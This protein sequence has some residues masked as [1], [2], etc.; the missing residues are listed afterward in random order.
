PDTS[1]SC[2]NCGQKLAGGGVRQATATFSRRKLSQSVVEG[3]PFKPQELIA[4]RYLIK[5]TVAA[6]PL[7]YLFRAHD[8]EIEVEVALKVINPKLVQ[9]AEERKAFARH[10][11]LARKLSHPNL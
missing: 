11:R 7:G 6:G 1:D 4:N 10:I 2:P 8:K 3:A 5:D 9:T